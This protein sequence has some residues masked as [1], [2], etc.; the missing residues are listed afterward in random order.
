M[1]NISGSLA[2]GFC[3]VM[4]SSVLSQEPI[5][6]SLGDANSVPKQPQAAIDVDGKLHVVYGDGDAVRYC[7]SIDNGKSFTSPSQAFRVPNMSLGMRRG[8][9]IAISNGT[10]VVTAIGGAQGKGRDGDIQAWNSRDGGTSWHGPFLVNDQV[11]SAR[12]GLHAMCSADD[13]TLWCV[14][15]DLRNKRSEIYASKSSDSGSTWQANKLLYQSPG[16]SVCEC[17]HPSVS[18][19]G[20]K[21]MV[22]FRNSLN[23]NRDMYLM[24]SEDAGATFSA[25]KK[26]GHGEWKLNACPMDG[27]MV[28]IDN[29]GNPVSVWRR[30]GSIFRTNGQ[31]E[32]EQLLGDGNQPW[33]ASTKTGPVIVWTNPSERQLMTQLPNVGKP[34]HLSANAA[35]PIVV[36][37]P[38]G[39]GPVHIFWEAKIDG[40]NAIYSLPLD[41]SQ[42]NP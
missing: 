21:V 37:H 20:D 23:G 4:A 42:S 15:L 29:E 18:V 41:I 39:D 11:S 5:Q 10:I 32:E 9:R 27:G 30:N 31:F 2:L 12:E 17:C 13:G 3:L 25:A 34:I 14:W 19:R 16:G 8:P 38:N 36:A 28:A 24:T 33:V 26:L 7:R 22:M 1:I 40:R 35:D 6:I